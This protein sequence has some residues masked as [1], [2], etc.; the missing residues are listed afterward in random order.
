MTAMNC[1]ANEHISHLTMCMTHD[2]RYGV[3]ASYVVACEPT[4]SL[5][6]PCS[7]RRD[8]N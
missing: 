6:T 4:R 1:T 5:V 7:L 3:V 2:L 8:T